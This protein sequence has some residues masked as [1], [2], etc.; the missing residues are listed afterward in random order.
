M[1]RPKSIFVCIQCGQSS[2]KWLGRCPGCGAWSS[3]EEEVRGPG[4][5]AAAP[6]AGEVAP[7]ALGEVRAE[8]ARRLR[9]GIGELDRALGGGVV[10]GGVVLLGGDPG[11]GKSTLLMQALASLAHRGHRTLYVTGEESAA[12]IGLRA[13]RLGLPGVEQVQV[14]AVTELEPV[15]RA[16][17]RVAPEVVVVDSIQTL[18]SAELEA[19]PGTVSQ[20]REVTGRLTDAA[21]K[22]GVGVFLI[23]HVTK[24]GALAGPKVLEHLVDTVLAFEGDASH[25]FR[26]VRATKNRF[27]ATHEVGVF[28][29]A[30]E[31]LREVADPS[32]LLL[33]ERPEATPG[34]IV[35]TTAEG[36]RPLCVEVQALVAKAAFGSARRVASGVDANRLGILLAVLERKVGIQVLDQDVFASVAGGVRVDERALDLAL[37]VAVVSSL[38][39]RPPSGNLAVFGEVGLAG[40]VRGVPRAGARVGEARKLGLTRIVLPRTNAESLS[41]EER[42]GLELRPVSRLSEA[43]EAAL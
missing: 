24:E 16:V 4:R 35:L 27:G 10:A 38:R 22:A 5:P 9:T 11:I 34:S 40:E 1:A 13:R 6:V 32:R 12:Q 15:E 28:E 17:E 8:E 41:A 19:S 30:Q 14:L 42:A 26:L 3:L 2:P 20:L 37:A 18:R 29:M 33:A 39:D 43:L 31:G 21:K 7:V 36:T 25:A 23:G